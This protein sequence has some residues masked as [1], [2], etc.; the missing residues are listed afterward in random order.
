MKTQLFKGISMAALVVTIAFAAAVV[1][2]N[3]Q[4]R[5]PVL[6][7]VPFDFVVGSKTLPAGNY[8]VRSATSS[9]EALVVR[10][11]DTKESIIRLTNVIHARTDNDNSKTRLIFHR[12]GQNYFLAEIWAGGDSDGRQLLQSKQERAMKREMGTIAQAT[13]ETI[14]IVATLR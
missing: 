11:S 7:Q 4:T 13:Y 2:A 6:S 12:Y 3:A 10:N 5:G 1:S 8:E 9:G 14:E